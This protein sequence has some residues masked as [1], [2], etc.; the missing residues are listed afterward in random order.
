MCIYCRF[1]CKD[2]IEVNQLTV[3]GK[4]LMS[5]VRWPI[6]DTDIHEFLTEYTLVQ[7]KKVPSVTHKHKH[8]SRKAFPVTSAHL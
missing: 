6:L 5:V 8:T 2:R 1:W 7:T 4:K 3:K